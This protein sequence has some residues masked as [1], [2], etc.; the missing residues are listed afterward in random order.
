[1]IKNLIRFAKS[2]LQAGFPFFSTGPGPHHHQ[3]PPT[4]MAEMAGSVNSSATSNLV[5]LL[6]DMIPI[7][8]SI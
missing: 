1:M 8:Q 6:L 4:S 2:H 7:K 5:I 3:G